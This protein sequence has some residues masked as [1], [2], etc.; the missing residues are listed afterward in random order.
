M[1]FFR[2][3]GHG[4]PLVLFNL[5]TVSEQ[6]YPKGVC[7]RS[8]FFIIAFFKRGFLRGMVASFIMQRNNASK[9]LFIILFLF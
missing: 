4:T 3:L 2:V 5:K 1:I 8:M 6:R 9:A 7:P